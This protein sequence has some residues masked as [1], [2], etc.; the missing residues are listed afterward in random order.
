MSRQT[1]ANHESSDE[2]ITG[3]PAHHDLSSRPLSST[4]LFRTEEGGRSMEAEVSLGSSETSDPYSPTRNMS[5]ADRMNS[6][7]RQ[8]ETRAYKCTYKD[9]NKAFYRRE[10]LTR[11]QRIHT[12]EKP[13]MCNAV[14]CWKRFSRM[15]ELKRHSKTHNK[16]RPKAVAEPVVP[17][18]SFITLSGIPVHHNTLPPLI[19]VIGNTIRTHRF[20][21]PQ[22][23]I[24][25]LA[26]IVS[27]ENATE[28][29][30]GNSKKRNNPLDLRNIL[31][32]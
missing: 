10:H 21:P 20:I 25:Y 13:Y 6:I 30:A 5:S 7:A 27:R 4:R 15:D 11:H 9:C 17:T 29:N 14:G 2:D 18:P 28:S 22:P 19:P 8:T 26:D 16:D 24:S 12:G 3:D 1:A 31:N 32:G 23:S